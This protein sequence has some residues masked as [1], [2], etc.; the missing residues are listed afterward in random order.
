MALTVV[1]EQSLRRRVV[2]KR[3]PRDEQY[4]TYYGRALDVRRIEAAIQDANFGLMTDLA[5]LESESLALDPHLN[6][7]LVKRFGNLQ[8]VDWSI[9]PASGPNI[10]PVL[11]QRIADETRAQLLTIPSFEES[12]YDLAWALFDGR[13]ALEIMW[14]FQ[15][16]RAP[17]RVTGLEWVHPRR[18][19]FGPERELLLIDTTSARGN[20][21]E[22]GLPLHDLPGKFIW[23]KPRLFREYPERE[24]L[25]PRTLYWAFFKRFG[26]RNRIILTELFAVPWR[27]IEI[28]KDALNVQAAALDDA[29][30]EAESLGEE[31]VARMGPGMHLRVE[32]PSGL[33][34]ASSNLL[35]LSSEACDRQMSKLVL[36]NTAT[37][38][39]NEANRSNSVTQRGEQDIIL[40]RDG[41]GLSSRI[42]EHLCAPIATLNFGASALSHAARFVLQ[43]DPPRDRVAD[44]DLLAKAIQLSVPVTVAQIREVTGAQEPQDD[45]PVIVV[46]SQS[47]EDAPGSIPDSDVESVDDLEQDGV[48]GQRDAAEKVADMLQRQ[49]EAVDLLL[50]WGM[51]EEA[52]PAILLALRDNDDETLLDA[53]IRAAQARVLRKLLR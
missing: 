11:A 28:D 4:R 49:G 23:W 39:G 22:Q 1:P 47:R 10:D 14:D 34:D 2:P 33:G 36:G 13:G 51:Q 45:E 41:V 40:H 32:W 30:R 12:I 27:I 53:G 16:G 35:E 17:W 6:S 46:A 43:T 9:E 15:T 50:E 29:F 44:M 26:W 5:D 7:V 24:G 20:F 48:P 38:D 25:G 8:A 18:L 31:A 52:L 19:A 42:D 21:V 37:T 3:I